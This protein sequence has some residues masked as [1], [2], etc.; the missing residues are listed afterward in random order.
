MNKKM[1]KKLCKAFLLFKRNNA[2]LRV[3]NRCYTTVHVQLYISQRNLIKV[4]VLMHQTSDDSCEVNLTGKAQS[5][6]NHAK[7]S[8]GRNRETADR[9][10]CDQEQIHYSHARLT[11]TQQDEHAAE[12]NYGN[13]NPKHTYTHKMHIQ[14][15]P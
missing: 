13:M 5:G 4:T 6:G 14:T 3:C 11:L 2:V 7:P 9:G 10:K 12:K 15:T 1:Q 8:I